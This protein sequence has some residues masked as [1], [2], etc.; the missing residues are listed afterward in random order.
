[1]LRGRRVLV[2]VCGSIA[3]YKAAE[4]VRGLIKEGADVPGLQQPAR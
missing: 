2:A 3:A 1:M 4:V